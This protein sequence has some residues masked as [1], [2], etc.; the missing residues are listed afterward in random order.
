MLTLRITS[1]KWQQ[2]DA[3]NWLQILSFLKKND[4]TFIELKCKITQI[5]YILIFHLIFGNNFIE[6]LECLKSDTTI[7]N[8][9]YHY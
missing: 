9:N 5:K 6:V 4:Q 7:Q 1:T 8:K 3:I 2:A